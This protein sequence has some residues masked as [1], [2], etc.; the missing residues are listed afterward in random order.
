ME[1]NRTVKY[2]QSKRKGKPKVRFNFWMMFIIFVLSFTACFV[3]YMLAANFNGD[4]F[5]DEFDSNIIEEQIQVPDVQQTTDASDKNN[6][7]E[8]SNSVSIT[9]PVPQSA[10]VDASYFDN[11]CLITDSTLIQMSDYGKF[12]PANIFS[13]TELNAVD[14]NTTKVS[15]NFGTVSVYDIIKN[16]KPDVLYIM[17]GSDL[18]TS[19]SDEMIASYT[20]LVNNLHSALNDMKIYVMQLPPVI[21]DTESITNEMI[22][23]YNNKLLAMANAIGVYCIDTNTALKSE[24][25]VLAEKFYSYETLALSAEGYSEICG[26]I[27][28]HTS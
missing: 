1:K 4:F 24:S 6:S 17:L 10:A 28:T 22:N 23:N 5:K 7:A 2:R 27:L 18:G 12:S 20:T 25:G 15:S 19:D 21:Y 13:S 8:N 3:L 16:K 26:Y 14:C 9:N 11:A